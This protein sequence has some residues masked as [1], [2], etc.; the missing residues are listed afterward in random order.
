MNATLL[1]LALAV[2]ACATSARYHDLTD[3]PLDCRKGIPQL[4]APDAIELEIDEEL[5]RRA[6]R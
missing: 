6:H 4:C 2:S 1:V 5:R 3:R